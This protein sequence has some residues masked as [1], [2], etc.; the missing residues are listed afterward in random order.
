MQQARIEKQHYKMLHDPVG[1]LLLRLSVPT[2]VIQLITV[3]Y[4]TADTYFVSQINTSAAAAVG[5][6]FSLMAV[7]QYSCGFG[8]GTGASSLISRF[9]GAEQ[10]EEAHRIGSSAVAVSLLMGILILIAVLCRLP[11]LCVLWAQQKPFCRMPVITR[12]LFYTGAPCMCAL[13]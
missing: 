5:V 6:V 4:N 2:G 12:V 1:R 3:I 9:L 10:N 8:V 7:I 13:C 11:R